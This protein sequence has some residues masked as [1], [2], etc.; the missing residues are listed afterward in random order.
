MLPESRSWARRERLPSGGNTTAGDAVY[1]DGSPR[2]Y[3]ELLRHRF[4]T[5]HQ[6]VHIT[7]TAVVFADGRSW[8][9]ECVAQLAEV[10]HDGLDPHASL[11]NISRHVFDNAVYR[12]RIADGRRVD[13]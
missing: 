3:L 9:T 7:H 11:L 10:R 13:R 1:R 4:A 8:I 2:S 5:A 12:G 6:G